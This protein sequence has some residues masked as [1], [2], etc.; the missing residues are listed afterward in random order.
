MAGPLAVDHALRRRSCLLTT[1]TIAAE[2]TLGRSAATAGAGLVVWLDRA[3]RGLLLALYALLAVRLFVAY[4]AGG[5]LASLLL[6]PSDGLVLFFLLI[7][8]QPRA[9][10]CSAG[11]WLLALAATC[12]PLLVS[13]GGEPLLPPTVA[14]LLLLV[15]LIVQVHAKLVLGRSIGCVPAN[16]GI[17]V[18]GPY[19]LVR[20]PIYAGYLLSHLGFLAINPT[21]WNAALYAVCIGLQVPRLL[22]EERLLR[23]DPQYSAYEAAVR[24]RLIPGV[25]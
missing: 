7:R 2:P 15:G 12:T 24:Y 13:P 5:S 23:R 14:A 1:T 6:L 25:F 11:E 4:E 10:S 16:R 3:E 19:R 8:R 18:A 20:H 21:P 17:K 9:L 22:R